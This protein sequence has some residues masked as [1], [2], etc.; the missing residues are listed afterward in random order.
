MTQDRDFRSLLSRR[1]PAALI[2]EFQDTDDLQYEIFHSIYEEAEG[3][4]F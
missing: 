1:W 2:D 4:L 3:P